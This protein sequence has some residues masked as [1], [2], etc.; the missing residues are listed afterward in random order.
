MIAV[1][2]EKCLGASSVITLLYRSRRQ[3]LSVPVERNVWAK[4]SLVRANCLWL[5]Q[6]HVGT[7][8]PEFNYHDQGGGHTRMSPNYIVD[9]HTKVHFNYFKS[10]NLTCIHFHQLTSEKENHNY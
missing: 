1:P 5:G 3:L 7:S 8:G 6:D 9:T 10:S 2:C 4:L